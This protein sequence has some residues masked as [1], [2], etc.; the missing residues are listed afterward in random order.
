M[1]SEPAVCWI[2]QLAAGMKKYKDEK[3]YVDKHR[4]SSGAR[5]RNEKVL[6]VLTRCFL[7]METIYFFNF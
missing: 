3:M 7:A 2:T 5:N 6:I 4:T 1:E